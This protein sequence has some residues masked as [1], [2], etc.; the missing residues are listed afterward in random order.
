MPLLPMGRIPMNATDPELLLANQ[1]SLRLKR[2]AMAVGTYGLALAMAWLALAGGFFRS[3]ENTIWII[4][5]LVLSSQLI[6]FS[7]FLRKINLRFK[8]PSLTLPQVLVAIALHTFFLS[9]L[10][11]DRGIFIMLY[12]MLLMFGAF[13][14]PVRVFAFCSSLVF[15]SYGALSVFDVLAREQAWTASAV[16]Q[17]L[18]LG[19]T[20]FWLTLFAGYAQR[21]RQRIRQRRVSLQAHQDTLRGMMQQLEDMVATDELTGLFN[22]RHFVRVASRELS[23]MRPGYLHGLAL[24]DLDN[25]KRIND[26][27]GH[28]V[29]DRVLQ[30]FASVA[31]TCLRDGDVL[32]RYGGEEFVLLLPNTDQAHFQNCCERLR[33]AFAQADMKGLPIKR[34]TLS[35]GM[36]MLRMSDSL[37]DALLR[38]DQ[39]MYRAKEAGRNRCEP[40][41][42]EYA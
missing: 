11:Q 29:G 36:T 21:M 3:P 5:A 18:M 27:H 32:A 31:S 9:C 12:V 20:L 8:D 34:A 14:L 25:F 42:I 10:Q 40:Y 15:V 16:L 28:A 6:F 22:R 4:T 41:W 37:D 26:A 35:V 7:L 30:T 24:I 17:M 2:F 19:L 23:G 38:A 1:Q 33:L 39:A 13:Q